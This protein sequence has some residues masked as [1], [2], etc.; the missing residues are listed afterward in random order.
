MINSEK[1]LEKVLKYDEE[2]GDLTETIAC[3]ARTSR[4]MNPYWTFTHQ[5]TITQLR[6]L[7]HQLTTVDIL[8]DLSK[9]TSD[10]GRTDAIQKYRNFIKQDYKSMLKELQDEFYKSDKHN[11]EKDTSGYNY[12]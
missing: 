1:L 6:A 12:Y 8:L 9:S 3:R 2:L 11:S 10:R 4:F 7:S 5:A